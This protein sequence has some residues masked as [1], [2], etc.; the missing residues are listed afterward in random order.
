[1]ARMGG[2][3]SMCSVSYVQPLLVTV[4]KCDNIVQPFLLVRRKKNS[5]I[6]STCHTSSFYNLIKDRQHHVFIEHIAQLR[7]L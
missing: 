1:M 5:L 3:L 4:V 6:I 2:R 7:I